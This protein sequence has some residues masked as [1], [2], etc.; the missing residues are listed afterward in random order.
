MNK[1]IKLPMESEVGLSIVK[2]EDVTVV[3]GKN[4]VT[5]VVES[6]PAFVWIAGRIKAE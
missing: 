4:T 3:A 2:T 6:D 1:L 5:V